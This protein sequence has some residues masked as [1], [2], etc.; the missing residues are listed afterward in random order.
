MGWTGSW[1]EFDSV[2]EFVEYELGTN[3][4]DKWRYVGHSIVG[5]T[6]YSLVENKTDPNDKFI[7]VTLTQRSDGE[8]LWKTMSESAGPCC[9]DCPVKFLKQSTCKEAYAEEWRRKCLDKRNEKKT[10]LAFMNSLKY[11]DLVKLKDDILVRFEAFYWPNPRKKPS[12]ST[13]V[14]VNV[15]KDM[16]F[17]YDWTQ[18]VGAN[19]VE[20]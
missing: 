16:R 3:Y 2:K 17:R 12:K 9:Y 4:N 20:A 10:A 14:A 1:R 15:Q 8:F 11:G 13:V 7:S 18:F 19:R 5:T 6:V